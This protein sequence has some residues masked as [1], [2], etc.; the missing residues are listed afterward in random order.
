MGSRPG[1]EARCASGGIT[2]RAGEVP[3]ASEMRRPPV[4]IAQRK[5]C[6]YVCMYMHTGVNIYAYVHVPVYMHMCVC[7]CICV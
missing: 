5:V 2:S 4:R 6:V 7:I 3:S 1:C